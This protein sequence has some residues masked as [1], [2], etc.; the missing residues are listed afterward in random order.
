MVHPAS[1]RR[2]APLIGVAALAWNR[3]QLCR[4]IGGNFVAEWVAALLWNQWQVRRG[5]LTQPD[6]ILRRTTPDDLG[7][8]GP[9]N[10]TP[11]NQSSCADTISAVAHLCSKRFEFLLDAV[12]DRIS[13]T[14]SAIAQVPPRH[15]SVYGNGSPHHPRIA[16]M[17]YRGNAFASSDHRHSVKR[18]S[19]TRD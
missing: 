14:V 10:K 2:P 17:A 6:E 16:Q 11:E 9:G 12:Q 3:W 1:A 4:G 18:G 8:V 7:P 5:I 19:I 15:V 13:Q